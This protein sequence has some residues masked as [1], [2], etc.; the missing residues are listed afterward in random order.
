MYQFSYAE[1]IEDD[2]SVARSAE[3]QALDRAVT[4]LNTAELVG[5]ASREMIEALYYTQK[6]WNAFVGDLANDD[7][8]LPVE[9]RAKLI[10]IGIWVMK[11]A[12]A[13]RAGKVKSC[14]AI[15]EICAIVRDGLQ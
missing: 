12:D 3:R 6:L 7:N 4:L 1:A 15:S 13:V 2:Q 9:V 10:S 14:S 5:P 8:V 11:E